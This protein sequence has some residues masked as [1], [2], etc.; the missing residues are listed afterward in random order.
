MQMLQHMYTYKSLNGKFK[1]P[2]RPFLELK[3]QGDCF[4]LTKGTNHCLPKEP[5]QLGYSRIFIHQPT[6]LQEHLCEVLVMLCD[7]SANIWVVLGTDDTHI[8]LISRYSVSD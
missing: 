8:F 7:C 6:R 1:G 5:K 3:L 2:D 4:A